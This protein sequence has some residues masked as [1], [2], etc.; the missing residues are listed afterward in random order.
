MTVVCVETHEAP[1]SESSTGGPPTR[2][3]KARRT[4]PGLYQRASMRPAPRPKGHDPSRLALSKLH[5]VV[6]H[7]SHAEL[8]NHCNACLHFCFSNSATQQLMTVMTPIS[9][10]LSRHGRNF[11]VQ[12]HTITF[13]H[14]QWRF[15]LLSTPISR[16]GLQLSFQNPFLPHPWG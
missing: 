2:P 1:S 11:V 13:T 9:N 6:L 3:L 10:R 14:K 5:Q 8:T 12:E 16:A 4:S 15:K 7:F